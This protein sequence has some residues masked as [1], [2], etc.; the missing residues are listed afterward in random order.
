M[1]LLRLWPIIVTIGKGGD[2]RHINHCRREMRNSDDGS[3]DGRKEQCWVW[4]IE[5]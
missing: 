4:I 1:K 3:A 5:L 2:E